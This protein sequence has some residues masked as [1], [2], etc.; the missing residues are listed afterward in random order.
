MKF[1]L[2][3]IFYL[4]LSLLLSF[5]IIRVNSRIVIGSRDGKRFADNS[6][7]F[8]Y[9][10]NKKKSL[11][12][13]WLTKSKKIENYLKK[14]KFRVFNTNSLIGLYYGF[15]AKYHVFDYS[16]YDTNEFS[17]IR[18]N[19]I[20]LGH[21]VY[22]KKIFKR[23]K[24]PNFF[25]NLYNYLV[26]KKNYHIYPNKKYAKHILN[27]FP[28][29]KYDLIV[30]NFPRNIFFYNKNYLNYGYTTSAEKKIINKI[31]LIKGK[32]IGYFPTWRKDSVDL[33]L[34]IQD[35]SKLS[36]L[37]NILKKNNS[38]MI[39]K[40]H[41][42]HFEE[43]SSIK[44]N[45]KNETINDAIK[46]YSNFINLGYDIDLNTILCFCD[47][48]ISDYSGAIVDY[49]ITAKPI[50]LYTPDFKKFKKNPGLFFNY[51]KLNFGHRTSNFEK[52]VKLLIKYFNNEK[53][54]SKKYLFQRKKMRN[55][56]FKN[57]IYF[58]D[59]TKLIK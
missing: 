14:K 21:G 6:R 50:I 10:L 25:Q 29:N 35:Y 13:A 28:K 55:I 5:L 8:F 47:L 27:Y 24:K 38:Y 19:K 12:V 48:L 58:D 36:K 9:F 15:K 22:L 11:N 45:K 46:N 3:R 54:F 57:D 34:D 31:N 23:V 44:F 33:F 17:S 43:D 39:I 37:N 40:H 41:P 18:A 59:I 49:L 1:N 30:S 16:E 32:K 53:K 52:L 2:K 26:N 51:N 7:Y 20:N 4:I 56:F 42:N